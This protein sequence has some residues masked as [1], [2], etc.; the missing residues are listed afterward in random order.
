MTTQEYDYEGYVIRYNVEQPDGRIVCKDAFRTCGD[1]Q[2]PLVYNVYKDGGVPDTSM[3]N[4]LG[5]A[6]LENREDGVYARCI[7]YNTPIGL[8]L[9]NNVEKYIKGITAFAIIVEYT[10]KEVRRGLI[11]AVKVISK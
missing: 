7:F 9:K 3:E 5:T 8:E 1:V 6:Y 2:V 4:V 10:A 11:R